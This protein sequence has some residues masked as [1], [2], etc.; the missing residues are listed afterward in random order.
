[1]PLSATD[2][3][4]ADGTSVT[5]RST[6]FPDIHLRMDGSGVTAAA[7]GGGGKVNCQ[8]GT[9][10]WTAY[11]LHAQTDG[12]YAFE[13][14]AFP[15][16]YLR[17]DGNGV[18]ATLAGGGTVN[19]QFG[20]GPWEKFLA[21]PQTDGSFS[22]ESAAFPGVFLRLVTGS[23]VTSATGPGGTVNCQIKA[24][25]GEHEKFFLDVA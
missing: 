14:K 21:R 10:P 16:V 7:D 18:P 15:G 1:M 8:Y 17:M 6:F 11:K 23:G 3:A 24:N 20:L 5:V 13:S 25:G 2:L 12:T 22:F 19:C 4:K 9:G